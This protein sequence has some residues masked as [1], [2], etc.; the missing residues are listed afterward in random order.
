MNSNIAFCVVT[1]QLP[2]VGETRY[3]QEKVHRN[4]LEAIESKRSE[5][6]AVFIE[7]LYSIKENCKNANKC[8]S[9]Y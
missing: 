1:V 4:F 6:L 8:C 9:F 3:N 2:T 7:I 5:G